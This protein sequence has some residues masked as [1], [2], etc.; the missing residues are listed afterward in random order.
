MGVRGFR[1]AY[2]N[3][4]PANDHFVVSA[5]ACGV[6]QGACHAHQLVLEVLTETGVIGLLLWL[7]GVGACDPGMAACD[8]SGTHTSFPRDALPWQ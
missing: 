8:A 1:Y 2:P 6:G 4:A 3:Y 7:G 5:E